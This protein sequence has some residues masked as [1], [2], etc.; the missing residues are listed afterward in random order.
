[1][2]LIFQE[3]LLNDKEYT[4]QAGED[5]LEHTQTIHSD[6][7]QLSPKSS[8]QANSDPAKEFNKEEDVDMTNPT[9]QIPV[10]LMTVSMLREELKRRGLPTKGLKAELAQRLKHAT[11]L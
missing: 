2:A 9:D 8:N 11:S 1:L 3:F 7:A 4:G 6:A 10:D 5:H